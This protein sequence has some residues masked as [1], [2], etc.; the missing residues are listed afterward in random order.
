LCNLDNKATP[1]LAKAQGE[2]PIRSKAERELSPLRLMVADKMKKKRR[3]HSFFSSLSSSSRGRHNDE[4]TN[5]TKREA[6]ERGDG[7]GR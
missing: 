6:L 3:K 2:K 1:T 4:K 7:G 5:A